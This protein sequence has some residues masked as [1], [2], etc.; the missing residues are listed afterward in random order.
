MTDRQTES[1]QPHGA[2]H[3][4]SHGKNDLHANLL[5]VIWTTHTNMYHQAPPNLS[6]QTA[7]TFAEI[8]NAF[9]H[10]L[11]KCTLC[12]EKETKMFFSVISPTK[13]GQFW[14]NLVYRFLN[15]FAAK[16]CKRFPP[17]LSQGSAETLFIWGRKH[18]YHFAANLFKKRCTENIFWTHCRSTL[19]EHFTA[20]CMHT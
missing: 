8:I 17:P 14:W 20:I 5:L 10:N 3:S 9:F 18:L 12:R 4:H 19:V 13:L 16:W 11:N 7:Y 15:K 1:Q 2:L 6:L